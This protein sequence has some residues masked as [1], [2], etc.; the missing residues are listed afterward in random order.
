MIIILSL[1]ILFFIWRASH[2]K[3]A[4]RRQS[5]FI[6]DLIA[7]QQ[8]DRVLLKNMDLIPDV[9]QDISPGLTIPKNRKK[10]FTSYRPIKVGDTVIHKMDGTIGIVE[11]VGQC[12]Y[13][14]RFQIPGKWSIVPHEDVKKI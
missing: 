2:W 9:A 5:E 7:R 11:K 10:G 12:T 13:E 4:S 14:V 1:V 3:Q 8:A 6:K